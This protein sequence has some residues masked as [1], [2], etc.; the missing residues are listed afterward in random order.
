[1]GRKAKTESTELAD[2]PVGE[3]LF[4]RVV[5]QKAARSYLRRAIENQ[6]VA[7][8]YLF[9]GPAGVG[10]SAIALDFAAALL[11]ERFDSDSGQAPC[12]TCVQC[13]LVARLQHPDLHI[14]A[15]IPGK[16]AVR[17]MEEVR[18]A[19]GSENAEGK[20]ASA[21]AQAQ[22]YAEV[23]VTEIVDKKL[24]DAI[25]EKARDPYVPVLL[26]FPD[27]L[28]RSLSILIEQIRIL[29]KQA[30]RMPF[31]A[32]R[33][34]FILLHADR[35][36]INAQNAFLKVLEEPPADTHFLLACEGEGALLP[37]IRSRCQP[38][39]LPPLLEP[40]IEEALLK[41][42][43]KLEES[44]PLISRLAGGN[45]WQAM[46][47]ARMKDWKAVQSVAVGYFAECSRLD[48]KK[49]EEFYE[50]LLSEEFGGYR[51]TLGTVQ[52]FMNDVAILKAERRI[53]KDMHL[54]LSH[55]GCRDRAELLLNRFP[56][57]SPERALQALQTACD[58]LERGYTPYS[59]LTALSFRLHHALG[60]KQDSKPAPKHPGTIQ[61]KAM[62]KAKVQTN[63]ISS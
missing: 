61:E 42:Y 34:V 16:A 57:V 48:P 43:P 9:T 19:S 24:L 31:Q 44:I 27:L 60:P 7:H 40:D 26:H 59:V 1:M 13:Q 12:R 8:A 63:D 22:D 11:C 25:A 35:M 20:P 49:L 14:V 37:T 33:K 58:N 52:L 17:R 41:R 62:K 50:N 29:I 2:R 21:T 23:P 39:A 47:L 6:R 5:G 3:P 36:N 18:K 38:I 10:K 32:R 55:Q 56:E 46:E 15:P 45:F 54:I 4:W 28:L 51:I 30:Y 53:G